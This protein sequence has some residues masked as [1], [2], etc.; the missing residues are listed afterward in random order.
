MEKCKRSPHTPHFS[1][2]TK[3]M[4]ILLCLDA[5][6]ACVYFDYTRNIIVNN[7]V[8][9][10]EKETRTYNGNQRHHDGEHIMKLRSYSVLLI[11]EIIKSVPKNCICLDE[12][13]L[14]YGTEYTNDSND[15]CVSVFIYDSQLPNQVL[16]GISES[17]QILCEIYL[18]H[19]FDIR[20]NKPYEQSL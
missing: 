16:H 20:Q 14:P 7:F 3:D 17:W 2:W 13:C 12:I 15:W 5:L 10:T 9:P 11:Y 1:P 8:E 4:K 6:F 18:T 19:P